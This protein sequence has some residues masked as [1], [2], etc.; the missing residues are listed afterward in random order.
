MT[1]GPSTLIV[2]IATAVLT[3]ATLLMELAPYGPLGIL[4]VGDVNVEPSRVF[5]ELQAQCPR[6]L[7]AAAGVLVD[8]SPR[9][10]SPR[11]ASRQC[12]SRRC[13]SCCASRCASRRGGGG[14][15]EAGLPHRG[16]LLSSSLRR[17][18]I[19][20][21]GIACSGGRPCLLRTRRACGGSSCAGGW[22]RSTCRC[23]RSIRG[24]TRST[25]G[26]SNCVGGWCRSTRGS[27][28]RRGGSGLR[29]GG[30]G[31]SLSEVR[32]CGT[33][34]PAHPQVDG[35]FQGGALYSAS[36]DPGTQLLFKHLDH[37][38]PTAVGVAPS[39][40]LLLLP[41]P[42]MSHKGGM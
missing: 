26:G 2:V 8:S 29:Q 25:R 23:S 27:R 20:C 37:S 15:G 3:S 21:G 39:R 17:C 19:A 13:A 31:C 7:H 35:G 11:C 12:A 36:F 18:G 32:H 5:K 41:T 34:L 42:K 22:R 6:H 16:A 4:L 40:H 14:L 1:L 38:T 28:R 33:L 30:R 24:R 10:A 9:C